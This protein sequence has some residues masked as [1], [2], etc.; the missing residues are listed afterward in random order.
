MNEQHRRQESNLR[1]SGSEPD[2]TTNSCYSGVFQQAVGCSGL[3]CRP[4]TLAVFLQPKNLQPTACL[5]VP[6][7]SRTDLTGLEVQDL[8][9]SANGTFFIHKAEG[10]RVEL[11]R[12]LRSLRFERSA[13][14]NR[15]AL[16]HNKAPA[17]GIE[18]ASG[19]LT[20]AFPY[21][22]RTHRNTGLRDEA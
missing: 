17:A 8:S 21:Q 9:R 18:P 12:H 19:R 15:L 13:V 16:P 6:C 20:V 14:A 2:A 22:H 1:A 3:D 11:A 7:R 10:A 4:C 5:R